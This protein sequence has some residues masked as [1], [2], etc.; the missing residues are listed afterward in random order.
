MQKK[1]MLTAVTVVVI[2][3]VILGGLYALAS[4]LVTGA[5]P[6]TGTFGKSIAIVEVKG[7]IAD[8]E[9]VI[10]DLKKYRDDTGVAAVVLRVDSP[11]GVVA[12]SQEIYEEVKKLTEKKP[13]VVSMGSVA[14][15]GGYYISCGADYIM[16]NPGTTT[17]S[18]GVIIEMMN[19]EGTADL[20]GIEGVVV[21][22]G[23]LKDVGN[24]F[25]AMTDKERRFLQE[26]VDS[27]Q[28]QFL[29]VVMEGRG[30]S[31]EDV[32]LI[33]D[34]RILTGAQA[35]E[36]GLVDELGNLEDAIKKSAELVGI[37]GEPHVIYPPKEKI[38][39]LDLMLQESTRELKNMMVLGTFRAE[40]RLAP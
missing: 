24:P 15:S 30:L 36:L 10:K 9:D 38:T 40:Y 6:L 25:R 27:L 23:D 35:L 21:K 2:C 5:K 33:S 29:A 12:P 26:Y 7:L 4:F 37:E 8:S 17:G 3:L 31:R 11:G 28:E 39:V 14:A 22:S 34:G 19:F 32:E 18:I 1:K 16:A 13:V 20:I